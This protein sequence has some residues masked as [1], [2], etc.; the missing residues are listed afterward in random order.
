MLKITLLDTAPLTIN[1]LL[2]FLGSFLLAYVALAFVLRLPATKL[3]RNKKQPNI[4][5]V[6]AVVIS[7][8]NIL[9]FTIID[10]PLLIAGL[11]I[12]SIIIVF[13]GTLDEITN[14][15]PTAQLISQLIIAIIISASGWTIRFI[16]DPW[17]EGVISLQLFSLGSLSVFSIILTSLWLVFLMNAINWIDGVD[18]LAG[19]IGSIAFITLGTVALL[20]SVQDSFTLSLSI[21]GA[22]VMIAF[23]IWNWPPAKVYLGTT[24][25]WFLG[26]FIGITA[27]VG[28]GKIATTLLV[29]AIPAFDA[30]LVTIQRLYIKQAPWQGDK[31][32]HLHH[33]LLTIGLSPQT[34]TILAILLSA[35]FGIAALFLQTHQ[36]LWTIAIIGALQTGAIIILWLRHKNINEIHNTPT[37]RI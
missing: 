30:I 6:G 24:G 18:G 29:L 25:S 28:G 35:S 22:G 26:L 36:K 17:S 12:S 32:H 7:L 1:H 9:C 31:T 10:Q 14:L 8:V 34:V 13:I 23:L 37:E 21:I 4:Y 3:R 27:I 33:R 16:S 2:L 5:Y 20:P 11:L 15:K 19:G